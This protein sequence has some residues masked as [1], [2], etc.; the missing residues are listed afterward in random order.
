MHIV[1]VCVGS[2]CVCLLH[3]YIVLNFFCLFPHCSFYLYSLSLS[4]SHFISELL[5]NQSMLYQ[6]DWTVQRLQSCITSFIAMLKGFM[7]YRVLTYNL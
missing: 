1:C 4:L 3:V 5:V 6:F 7:A 2:A